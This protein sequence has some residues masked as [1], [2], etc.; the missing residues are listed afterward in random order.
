[1]TATFLGQTRGHGRIMFLL[2]RALPPPEIRVRVC[3][4]LSD[5]PSHSE[6]R[7]GASERQ[8]SAA[9]AVVK[10]CSISAVS[11]KKIWQC[12]AKR[13]LVRTFMI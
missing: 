13:V 8:V 12:D 11:R 1:M 9:T 10:S 4:A 3:G 7:K 2:C 6:P 5:D